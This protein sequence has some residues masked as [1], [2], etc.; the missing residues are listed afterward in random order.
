MLTNVTPYVSQCKLFWK[1]QL[2]YKIVLE[3]RQLKKLLYFRKSVKKK[4]YFKKY[5]L[6]FKLDVIQLI[7]KKCIINWLHNI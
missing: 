5:Y 2:F 3:A 1:S 7:V 4:L 6:I